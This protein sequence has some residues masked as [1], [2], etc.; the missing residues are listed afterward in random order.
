MLGKLRGNNDM[1]ATVDKLQIKVSSSGTKST[2]EKL[3]KLAASIDVL[4]SKLTKLNQ[5]SKSVTF[6]AGSLANIKAD[7]LK[8]LT[9]SMGSTRA[10]KNLQNLVESMSSVETATPTNA[11]V[12]GMADGVEKLSGDAKKASDNVDKVSK[13]LKQ[14]GKDAS[15][16]NKTIAKLF[17]SIGRIA[18]YRAIRTLLSTI[19]QAVKEGIQNLKEW[20]AVT[21]SAIAKETLYTLSAYNSEWV[22]LQNTLAVI[23]LP[24]IEA[25]LPA[26]QELSAKLIQAG[27]TI[28]QVFT[29]L[30]DNNA[31]TYLGINPDYF[32]EVATSAKK[33]NKQLQKFDELNNLTT[34]GSDSNKDYSKMFIAKDTT[35][36]ISVTWS[37]IIEKLE[38]VGELMAA[39]WVTKQITDFGNAVASLFRETGSLGMLASLLKSLGEL[40]IIGVVIPLLVEYSFELATGKTFSEW[41]AEVFMGETDIQKELDNWWEKNINEP[42]E[43]FINYYKDKNLWTF[44]KD[45]IKFPVTGL[46]SLMPDNVA[47]EI[48]GWFDKNVWQPI[49]NTFNPMNLPDIDFDIWQWINDFLSGSLPG[50]KKIDEWWE[51]NVNKPI[52][53]G[54]NNL[55]NTITGKNKRTWTNPTTTIFDTIKSKVQEAIDKVKE[56]L[57]LR[58]KVDKEPTKPAYGGSNSKYVM[59]DLQAFASGGYPTTGELFLANE[60]GAEMVGSI[61]GRTAVANNDQI[62]AAIASACYNA[63]A[64]ALSENKTNVVI[65]GDTSKIFKVVQQQART[66]RATTGTYAF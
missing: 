29:L 37:E 18:F 36:K 59:K 14:A 46:A 64:Q 1:E 58:D 61:G 60:A 66:F 27:D 6:L 30:G 17:R 48:S 28:A 32:E 34:S 33:A 16:S 35:M 11:T 23:V 4:H 53:D 39:I 7:G 49:K 41:I 54:I 52:S 42:I 50:Q 5:I 25:L 8:S 51:E 21:D 9:N 38:K 43:G 22:K 55:W 12:E 65:Q 26:I 45:F 40:A 62:T 63:M 19:T 57:G 3:D 15:K 31:E 20:S 13:S 44:L 10:V 2:A 24:V 56:F 47:N